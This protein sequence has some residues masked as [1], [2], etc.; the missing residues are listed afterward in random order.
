MLR[1]VTVVFL[2]LYLAGDNADLESYTI[3]DGEP[4]TTFEKWC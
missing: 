4:V 1:L 2:K 3:S